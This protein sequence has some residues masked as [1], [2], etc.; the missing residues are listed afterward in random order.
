MA[1]QFVFE[2]IYCTRQLDINFPIPI[3]FQEALV[4]EDEQNYPSKG[5]RHIVGP[6][7]TAAGLNANK[8]IPFF[9]FYLCNH[10][11]QK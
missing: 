3:S 6:G 2:N 8:T 4:A 5:V 10:T 9:L 11:G 1:L 7:E